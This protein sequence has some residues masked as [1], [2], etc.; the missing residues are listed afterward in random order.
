MGGKIIWQLSF[1]DVL[2]LG[3][4][5][6]FTLTFHDYLSTERGI[7]LKNINI[8]LNFLFFLFITWF[9]FYTKRIFE[10]R[11]WQFQK[12]YSNREIKMK[13][14]TLFLIL[15]IFCFLVVYMVFFG[16]L[17][18]GSKT[19][20]ADKILGLILILISFI[21]IPYVVKKF[22]KYKKEGD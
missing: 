9:I 19:N 16:V 3:A 2:S 7:N 1:L 17:T 4:V 12:K 8:V 11:F 15:E 14:S 18:I 13:K 21:L 10:L 22:I 5:V 20:L 6:I